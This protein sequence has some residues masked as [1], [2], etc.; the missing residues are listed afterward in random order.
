MR[1]R[2]MRNDGLTS[3]FISGHDKAF[4][5]EVMINTNKCHRLANSLS[6]QMKQWPWRD[7][8]IAEILSSSMSWR[9]N[10]RDIAKRHGTPPSFEK[11]ELLSG[12]AESSAEIGR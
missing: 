4:R 6:L 1:R 7:A 12:V 10:Y 11:A 5:R 3:A 8:N 9:I 2:Y